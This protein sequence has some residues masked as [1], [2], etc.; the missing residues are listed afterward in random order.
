MNDAKAGKISYF[1]AVLM[2]INIMVGAGIFSGVGPMTATAESISFLGW[3][4]IGLLLFP[5]VWC[6]AKA[7]QLFPGEGGFYHYCSKGISPLTGFIAQWGFFLGYMGTAASLATVLREG[8]ARNMGS[9]LITDYAFAFNLILVA[10][11]VLL[12]LIP[13]EKLSRIQSFGTLLKITPIL[14]AIVL[15]A[16]YFNKEMSFQLSSL[17]N[18]GLTVSTVLFSFW[19]FETCC[20]IGGLLKGGP[21][22]VG[23]VILVGFFTTVALYFFFHLGV[24]YIMGPENLAQYGAIEFPRFLG[25]SPT[26]QMGLQVA[27]TCAILLSWANSIL[28]VSLANITN[29]NSLAQRK[30]LLGHEA[31]TTV[32]RYDRP[33]VSAFVYGAVFFGLITTITDVDVLFSLT[34]LGILTA[35]SLTLVAVFRAQWQ[36]RN[37]PQ[38]I[39]SLIAFV[40]CSALIYYTVVKLPS[41]FY[42]TPLILGMVGG[43]ILYKLQQRKTLGLDVEAQAMA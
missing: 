15:L 6:I 32:N 4:L 16:F 20:S 9:T 40:C 14:L 3:P 38:I 11:Y 28:G 30:L 17:S 12:N 18:I 5:V 27:I 42:A 24:L 19:G 37:I 29:L 35:I 2:S 10:F 43:L 13:V 22:K 7:A 34:G 1:A 8:L 25:L 26:L 41:I 39:I 23:S 36:Q 21:Q 33:Y 31:L